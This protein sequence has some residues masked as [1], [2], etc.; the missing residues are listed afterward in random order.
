MI[1]DCA[2]ALRDAP[3]IPKTRLLWRK[4]DLAIGKAGIEAI[5]R[6]GAGSV[7]LEEEDIILPDLLT[8]LQDRTQLTRRS[9]QRILTE[10]ERLNDF[11]LNPQQFIER[12]AEAI[13]RCK[14][15]ALVGGIKYQRLGDDHYYAQELFETKE[16]T[17][18]LR[19]LLDV[20]KSVYKKVVYD[21]EVE[22]SF[23][24]QM[25]KNNAVKVYAKLPDW[26][27]I[28]TPLGSYNP[29][30]A[31]LLEHEGQ[32]RLYFVVET[33]GK[34]TLSAGAL[35]LTEQANIVCGRAYFN[36]LE[37]K[38]DSACY[39]VASTPYDFL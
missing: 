2:N 22:K 19:N 23:A 31:V 34:N 25:E 8:D 15:L 18:Y 9:I 26:F 14:Q 38:K 7:V 1:Q 29:D 27:T 37:D 10:S 3:P 33:K 12:A 16:L 32:E 20:K 6:D 13:N 36:A 4:A 28:P 39:V 11:K 21:S 35:R 17:G 5:E 24:D 30:W